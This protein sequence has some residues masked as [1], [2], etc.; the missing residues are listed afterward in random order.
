MNRL[1]NSKQLLEYL[2]NIGIKERSPHI[3]ILQEREFI[4]LQEQTYKIGETEKPH[5][6]F[7]GYAKSSELQYISKVDDV[8]FVEQSAKLRFKALFHQKKEYGTE[9]FNGNIQDMISEIDKIICQCSL[10]KTI[11][12]GLRFM[13]KKIFKPL[14][15]LPMKKCTGQLALIDQHEPVQAPKKSESDGC[16]C[17]KCPKYLSTPQ[18]VQ[19]H[20][21]KKVP[22][23][24]KCKICDVKLSNTRTYTYHQKTVHNLN[25]IARH[26]SNRH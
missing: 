21:A 7:S 19:S 17:P 5:R 15:S 24:F 4:R 12:P 13:L 10:S 11:T 2:K 8:R 25:F 20:L 22:C 14:P 6:R 26:K 18:R 16:K 3:Y 1:L 9:Y 23:D